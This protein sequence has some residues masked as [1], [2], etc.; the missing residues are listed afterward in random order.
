MEIHSGSHTLPWRNANHE[1]QFS[2]LRIFKHQPA[3]GRFGD[4]Q[5]FRFRRK[6]YG[7]GEHGFDL[8][9][10]LTREAFPLRDTAS[11]CPH[12]MRNRRTVSE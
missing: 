6:I 2:G 9:R 5:E 1:V 7:P 10:C 11:R 12:P 3:S 4:Q 8:C